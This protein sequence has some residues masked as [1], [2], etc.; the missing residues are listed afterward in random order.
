MYHNSGHKL[1]HRLFVW[2]LQI[3]PISFAIYHGIPQTEAPIT[4]SFTIISVFS[5]GWQNQIMLD[6]L[7]PSA[8]LLCQIC[9]FFSPLLSYSKASSFAYQ[10]IPIFSDVPGDFQMDVLQNV[11]L[12]SRV[13]LSNI[14]PFLR[15]VKTFKSLQVHPHLIQ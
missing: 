6:W 11:C 8:Y 4:D 15:E 14:D 3:F 7:S 10:Y 12:M 9:S 5:T 13:N 1:T 2:P